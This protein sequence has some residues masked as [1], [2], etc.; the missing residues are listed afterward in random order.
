MEQGEQLGGSYRS[1]GRRWWQQRM[2]EVDLLEI[3][4]AGPQNL[5]MDWMGVGSPYTAMLLHPCSPEL[6]TENPCV[7]GDP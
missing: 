3:Y 7:A 2:R 5:L 1:P 6:L 4:L